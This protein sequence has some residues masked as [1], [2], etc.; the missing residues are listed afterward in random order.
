MPG[1]CVDG[2]ARQPSLPASSRRRCRAAAAHRPP[3]P[4]V[5]GAAGSLTA[6]PLR[7]RA[8]RGQSGPRG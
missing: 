4:A 7:G 2:L 3:L 8:P 5:A 1:S 6:S